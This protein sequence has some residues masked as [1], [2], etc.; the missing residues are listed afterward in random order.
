MADW[1][2][3]RAHERFRYVRCKWPTLEEVGEYGNVTGGSAEFSALSS[4]K[5]TCSFDFDGGTPPDTVD[6]V[7]VWYEFTDDGGERSSTAI[8]TWLPTYTEV[9]YTNTSDGLRASGTVSG[10]SMLSVLSD[11]LL[12]TALTYAQGSQTLS[13]VASI[14]DAHNLSYQADESQHTL[15]G[16]HTF[17]PDD[18]WLT[19]VN[20]L[21]SAAGFESADCDPYGRIVL[22]KSGDKAI[23]WTFESGSRSIMLPTVTESNDYMQTANAVRVYFESDTAGISAWCVNKS[24]GKSSTDA[25]GGREKTIYES[26]NDADG[27]TD[28]EVGAALVAKARQKLIDNSAE[29]L[30]LKW[31]HAFVPIRCGDTVRNTYGGGD[32]TLSTTNMTVSFEPSAECETSGRTF[33]T[34]A[35]AESELET[36]YRVEWGSVNG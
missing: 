19:V 25:R 6:A 23:A 9:S 36:G 18:S 20:W 2:G 13:E 29:I 4:V 30:H 12:G 14:L 31:R 22:R 21:L 8:G 3:N 34:T 10:S 24:H 5:G 16:S 17:E 7:R 28:A 15:P 11:H 33:L 27:A 26:V 35:F 32:W 1:T